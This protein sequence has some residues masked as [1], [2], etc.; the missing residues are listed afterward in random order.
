M[1]GQ[2]PIIELLPAARAVGCVTETEPFAK[3]HCL[4]WHRFI[5]QRDPVLPRVPLRRCPVDT[6]AAD[7]GDRGLVT[8]EVADVHVLLPFR[9]PRGN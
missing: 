3:S 6:R 2:L 4:T 9:R 1:L 7:T 8:N 5:D